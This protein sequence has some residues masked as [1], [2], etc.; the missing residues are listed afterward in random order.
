VV[1]SETIAL[2]N[3]QVSTLTSKRNLYLV[4]LPTK[5]LVPQF[6]PRAAYSVN[7][8]VALAASA[9]NLLFKRQI[10]S[11]RPVR[12]KARPT[13]TFSTWAPTRKRK[14]QSDQWI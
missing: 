14:D 13:T 4:A 9:G 12:T 8:R 3:K 2:A 7:P 10:Y 5:M 6:Q 11:D 1:F